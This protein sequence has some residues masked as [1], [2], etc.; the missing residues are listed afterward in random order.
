MDILALFILAASLA[1][2]VLVVYLAN[3][4]HHDAALRISTERGVFLVGHWAW[5]FIVLFTGGFIGAF[6][7]WIIHYSALRYSPKIDE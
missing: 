6:A 5:F 2:I 4:V 1:V 7:Y 3:A